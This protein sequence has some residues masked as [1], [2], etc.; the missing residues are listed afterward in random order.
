MYSGQLNQ[1]KASETVEMEKEV[2]EAN[3]V[4]EHHD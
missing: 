1:T 3:T 4:K 2:P